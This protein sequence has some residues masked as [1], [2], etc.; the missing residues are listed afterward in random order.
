MSAPA[1]FDLSIPGEAKAGGTPEGGAA[2]CT[3][4]F[5]VDSQANY[6]G[7]PK[8]KKQGMTST[9]RFLLLLVGLALVGLLF[10]GY[11]IY[12]LYQ[13]VE[14]N[15]LSR[16]HSICQNQ[17][18]RETSSQQT[19]SIMSQVG[20]KDRNQITMQQRPFAH[21]LGSNNLTS[22]NNLMQWVK[23]GDTFTH[24]MRHNKD[25]LIVEKEGFYYVYSKVQLNAAEDCLL[26]QHKVM[27]FTRAYDKPIGLMKSRNFRCGSAKASAGKGSN[28][29][30]L[31]ND[32]LA[33]IFHLQ[34]GDK[35]TVQLESKQNVQMRPGPSENF[36]GAFM[37]SASKNN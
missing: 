25:G 31:W 26:I 4:V 1:T 22:E 32:Y 12:K 34:E 19:G 15:C 11:F 37:I 36:M 30:D 5:V 28:G 9:H 3:Q 2:S 24:D 20:L 21:L 23:Q 16:F 33:G 13:K 35:I 6:L 17:S 18:N 10:E 29:E 14:P 8:H 7:M 27:K